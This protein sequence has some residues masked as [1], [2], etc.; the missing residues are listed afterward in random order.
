MNEL[1]HILFVLALIAIAVVILVYVAQKAGWPQIVTWIAFGIIFLV[2][3]AALLPL[4]GV[5]LPA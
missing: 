3:L 5:H 2:A 1:F 4:L